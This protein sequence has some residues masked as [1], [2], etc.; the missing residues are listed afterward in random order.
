MAS[1]S[2][3]TLASSSIRLKVNVLVQH[4]F[5]TLVVL[6]SCIKKLY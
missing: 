4:H 2:T 3:A 5:R 1:N 6:K